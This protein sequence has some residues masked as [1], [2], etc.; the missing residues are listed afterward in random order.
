MV[1]GRSISLKF[2]PSHLESKPEIYGSGRGNG[3]QQVIKSLPV[4]ARTASI[5]EVKVVA[6]GCVGK[7]N[8][9]DAE[10]AAGNRRAHEVFA[11]LVRLWLR[12]IADRCEVEFPWA[13]GCVLN[14]AKFSI[15]ID[16]RR[17]ELDLV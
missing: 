8:M 10:A 2:E 15:R 1:F 12:H 3:S 9:P 13:A 17:V 14:D 5:A 4:A 6:N 11:P 7:V 16:G